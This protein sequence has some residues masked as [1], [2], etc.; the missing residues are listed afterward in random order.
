MFSNHR[1][2]PAA[3]NI[4]DFEK[5]IQSN[6]EFIILLEVRVSQVKSLVH[7]AKRHNKKVLIHAD[8]IQGL[9][10][11]EYAIE[12][13]CNEIKPHGIISTRA[14]V[15]SRVKKQKLI[16]IQ[17]LFLLDSHALEH[18]L[19]LI[20]KTQPD[21]I[22]VLP[23]LVPKLIKEIYDKVQIPVIAG[24]LIRTEEDVQN[25]IDGGAIAVT[26]SVKELFDF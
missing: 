5:L 7:L 23:G 11:D 12:F 13:L 18:N 4:K 22:E 9:K 20:Q 26:S 14:N 16:A 19:S 24:G 2:L 17:R 6:A 10:T 25:A 15:I 8:L 3:R 21:Y 1:V